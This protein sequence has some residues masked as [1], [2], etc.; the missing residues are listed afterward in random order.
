MRFMMI[1][2]PNLESKPT[3]EPDAEAVAAMG[4]Y[5]AELSEAGALLSLDG[6]HPPSEGARVRFAAGKPT[7]SDGPFAETK[8]VLGGYWLIDVPGKQE[9]VAW[10]E[11]CPAADGDMIEVRRVY[12]MS[13]FPPEVQAAAEPYA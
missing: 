4:A 7:T 12:E 1:M 8:E 2:Y 5:N 13:D 11:R 10:A 9:A 6:L 3:W